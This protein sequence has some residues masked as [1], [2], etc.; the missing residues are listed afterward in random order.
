MV[1]DSGVPRTLDHTM[2][3]D[4]SAIGIQPTV[5]NSVHLMAQTPNQSWIN[6]DTRASFSPSISPKHAN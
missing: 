3:N 4:M 1:I 5:V 2:L 6:P